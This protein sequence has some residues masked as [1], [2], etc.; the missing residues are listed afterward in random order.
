MLRIA[1][2]IKEENANIDS[3]I[4]EHMDKYAW[5]KAPVVIEDLCFE[6]E[7][8]IK[9]L[10]FLKNVDINAKIENVIEIRRKNDERYLNI[11][12][13]YNFSK[14]A[15][16][17]IK[18]IRDFIFLRTYTTEY[19]DH[20]FYV[21]R[22]TIFVELAKRCNL[23]VSDI[24]MLGM[25]E[26]LNIINNNYMITND[27]KMLINKRKKAFAIVCIDGNI[28]SYVG[29]EALLLQSEIGKIYK[30]NNTAETTED[31]IKGTP[32]N[33][34]K[35]IGKV[36]ILL[37]YK[38]IFKVEKGD[39]IVATMT[40]PD[41][42]SAMEKSAGFITDEGGITCHAAIISREFNVPC[43]VGTNNAT[44]KLKNGQ[45]VELDAFTGI[46]KILK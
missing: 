34:G 13:K 44:Q 7:D 25:D 24:I 43:I 5:I 9:R 38:D 37:D 33:R 16:K 35:V 22:H 11:L 40:T 23:E 21:A 39:I 42:V 29:E 31:F 3:L 32:A 14:K 45:L 4:E 19:S 10:D 26:I 41:Y 17:L 28:S 1:K 36:K 15:Q 20:L 12:E 30:V 2:R 8:Y 46:I 18:A 6:K 27:I